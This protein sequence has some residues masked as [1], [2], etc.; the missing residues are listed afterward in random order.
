ME[1]L[2]ILFVI[3]LAVWSITKMM[4]KMNDKILARASHEKQNELLKEILSKL[5]KIW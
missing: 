5:E 2:V 4:E 3:I 1:F